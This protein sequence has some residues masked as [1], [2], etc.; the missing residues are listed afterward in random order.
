MSFV[1]N[2]N[3]LSEVAQR[4]LRKTEGPLQQAMTRLSSGLRINSAKDDAAGLA[5]ATRMTTQIRGLTVAVRNANDG[6]SMVQ[7]AEGAIDEMVT[8]LQRI[9]ELALQAKSG[10][11]SAS[12][13][14]YMQLEVDALIDEIGRTADQTRFNNKKVFDGYFNINLNVSYKAT[15]SPINL[16]VSSMQITGTNNRY[17]HANTATV[18]TVTMS[19]T[20]GTAAAATTLSSS[21]IYNASNMGAQ[22]TQHR[23]ASA[24]DVNGNLTYVYNSAFW[25]N[26]NAIKGGG[27]TNP[28][29]GPLSLMQANGV[30]DSSLQAES[31]QFI[32]NA[33]N[34]IL[35][36]DTVLN[37]VT[38]ERS[39]LGAKANQLEAAIR[40]M[41]NQIETTTASKS[42]I[43]DADFA[44]ETASLTKSLILQQAGISVL[45]QANSIPQNILALLR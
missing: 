39:Y 7:T 19:S 28:F 27:S 6:L 10:Q 5:I 8:N 43:M 44:S 23:Y 37:T 38:R 3:I 31:M 14:Q 42:R 2:T 26:L 11:Y 20:P 33:S 4:Q 22:I 30:Y 18:V 12:D 24:I 13:V 21:Q 1:I 34:T 29:S 40:N 9:R 17:L 32:S 41:D 16:S 25:G 36:V 15:D 35:V 45:S